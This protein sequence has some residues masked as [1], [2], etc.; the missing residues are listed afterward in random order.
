MCSIFWQLGFVK[1]HSGKLSGHSRKKEGVV[2]VQ[3]LSA[4]L[5]QQVTSIIKM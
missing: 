1:S 5:L 4:E 3:E 2:K